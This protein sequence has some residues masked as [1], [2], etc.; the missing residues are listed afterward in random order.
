MSELE[1]SLRKLVERWKYEIDKWLERAIRSARKGE[2][3]PP[4]PI[5]PLSLLKDV[6]LPEEEMDKRRE[7]VVATRVSKREME[8][9]NIL[10]EA[11]FFSTKSEAIA[12]LIREGIKKN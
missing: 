12:F 2:P 7:F 9:I 8:L 4:L 10:V 11:G 3:L 1:E 6:M 5:P